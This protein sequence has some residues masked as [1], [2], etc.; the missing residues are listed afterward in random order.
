MLEVFLFINPIGQLCLRSEEALLKIIGETDANIHFK[1]IPVL[2]LKNVEHY[3]QFQQQNS[4]DLNSR[5]HVFSTIYEAVL[6]YK[7][8]TFQGGKKS[9][10][11]LMQLQQA[12]RE[13]DMEL[14][15]ELVLTIA[16][17]V[18]LDTEMLL[19]DWHSPLTKQAFDSDQQLSCE[20][21]IQM[22]P[23]AVVFNYSKGESE[24][25]LL[26]E[27][28]DSYELLK[29]ACCAETTPEQTFQALQKQKS[30]LSR[31]ALH[32]IS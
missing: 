7:A 18:G 9:Q 30:T 29:Q 24:S 32:V 20:M 27:N 15:N 13:P 28:C 1:F 19:E 10:S 3:M 22:T 26:I 23:S 4:H 11:F 21:N 2:N 14:N 12:F 5:N 31:V 17:R 16:K 25:G 6:A 8:A